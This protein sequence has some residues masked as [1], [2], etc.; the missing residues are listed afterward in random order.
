MAVL[1]RPLDDL[2][3]DAYVAKLTAWR[4]AQL[5][6][7]A[8]VTPTPIPAASINFDI[9]RNRAE[10]WNT[11]VPLVNIALSDDAYE[12]S[13]GS[14][15]DTC[16]TGRLTIKAECYA[17]LDEARL[18]YLK[19]QALAGLFSLDLPHVKPGLTIGEFRRDSW[20]S[21]SLVDVSDFQLETDLFVGAWSW[22]ALYAWE[23]DETDP[24][25]LSDVSVNAGRWSA[26]YSF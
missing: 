10:A 4:T 13:K 8:A 25:A 23:P 14:N 17:P 7:A 5:A 26:L 1:P 19:Y 21:W 20:P 3:L 9:D 15:I 18:L 11:A 22:T 16:R 2:L 12:T 24:P 6:A